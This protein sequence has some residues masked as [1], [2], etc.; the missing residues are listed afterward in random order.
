MFPFSKLDGKDANTLIFPNLSSANIAHK[1]LMELSDSE[2]IGPVLNGMNKP[3]HVL[4]QGS[5]VKE[6]VDMIMVS[7]MDAAKN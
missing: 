7:V 3:V 1:L 2:A 5:S 6:I 4:R